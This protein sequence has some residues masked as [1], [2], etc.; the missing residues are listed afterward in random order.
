MVNFSPVHLVLLAAVVFLLFGPK[1]LPELARGV[2]EGMKE[3]KKAMHEISLDANGEVSNAA[4]AA[5]QAK[6]A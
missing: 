2:G 3:F 1:R 4:D 5:S 6:T